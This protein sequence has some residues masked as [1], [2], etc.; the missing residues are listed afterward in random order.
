MITGSSASSSATSGSRA[1]IRLFFEDYPV[2]QI[3]F[4]K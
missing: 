2:E 4:K 1:S 3:E